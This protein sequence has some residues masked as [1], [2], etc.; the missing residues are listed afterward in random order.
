MFGPGMILG[1]VAALAVVVSLFLPWRTGG[2]HPSDIPAAFLWVAERR[3]IRRC[4]SS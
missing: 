4:S 1:L 3:R 2:V